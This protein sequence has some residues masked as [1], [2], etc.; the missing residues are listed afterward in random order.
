MFIIG[1]VN[2]FHVHI[3]EMLNLQ[4]AILLC[5]LKLI[6]WLFMGN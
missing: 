3:K 1:L 4:F 6:I 2:I 5:L